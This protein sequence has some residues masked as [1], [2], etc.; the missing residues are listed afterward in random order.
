MWQPIIIATIAA[1]A[2]IL[3]VA[4]AWNQARAKLTRIETQTNGKMHNLEQRIIRLEA[5]TRVYPPETH[6]R[7]LR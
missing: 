2:P 1:I 5:S 7:P 4:L 6:V 3:A